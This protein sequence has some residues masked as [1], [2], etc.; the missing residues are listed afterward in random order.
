MRIFGSIPIC[1]W[2]RTDI[3]PLSDQAKLLAIYLM[4]G[5]HSNML[6]CFRLP[7]GYIVE[8]LK[9]DMDRVKAATDEL[10]NI[11]F[12]SSDR[13]FAWIVVHDFLKWNPIQ[14]P[15]QAI[16]IEKLFNFIPDKTII[17]KTL[18]EKLLKYGKYLNE[19]FV[20]RLHT[21]SEDR[22]TDKE[23]DNNT[24]QYQYIDKENNNLSCFPSLNNMFDDKHEN[25]L[26]SKES[27]QFQTEA[28]EILEFLNFKAEKTF[29]P[30]EVNLKHIIARL[31]EGIT[32][33]TCR[34]VVVRKTNQWKESNEM[35]SNLNPSTLFKK[36]HFSRYKGELVLPKE[37]SED[38]SKQ[39]MSGM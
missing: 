18:I 33:D 7:D 23:Q 35:N 36:E 22:T 20:K 6:G 5:P 1:F 25:L 19:G 30:D 34:Q 24:D 32:S 12:L 29:E 31:S 26:S 17:L 38:E 16:G 27:S 39:R 4:T 11:N 13:K 3:Q 21:L 10:I 9:W 8:D 28:I 37:S 2:E 14:N 15:K